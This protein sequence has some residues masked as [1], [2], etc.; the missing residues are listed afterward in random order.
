MPPPSAEYWRERRRVEKAWRRAR[1]TDE[2]IEP[3]GPESSE[4][5]DASDGLEPDRVV[6][7]ADPA[8]S[9]SPASDIQ[10]SGERARHHEGGEQD[11]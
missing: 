2:E 8:G 9:A 5:A 1:T 4:D 6:T 7:A 10:D 11:H 3:G